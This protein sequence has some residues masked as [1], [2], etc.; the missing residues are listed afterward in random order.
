[1]E[2]ALIYPLLTA[3]LYYLAARAQITSW[4]WSRYE[5]YPRFDG[6]MSCAA[7]SG[8]WYGAIVST[9]GYLLDWTFIG[10]HA[11]WTIPVVATCSIVWTPI[12]SA[13]QEK[14]LRGE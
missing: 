4:L 7:C 2:A 12:I 11:W 1:M 14:A 6:F 3:A 5:K 8:F 10:A 13:M 9:L